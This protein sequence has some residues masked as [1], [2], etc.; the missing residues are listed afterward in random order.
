MTEEAQGK[1]GYYST[2][3]VDTESVLRDVSGRALPVAFATHRGSINIRPIKEVV[4]VEV[5][6]SYRGARDVHRVEAKSVPRP[7]RWE[8]LDMRWASGVWGATRTMSLRRRV[9]ITKVLYDKHFHGKNL[10]K[11]NNAEVDT[12]CKLCH[13]AR[14]GQQHILRECCEP[15]MVR[16]RRRQETSLH[17]NVCTAETKRDPMAR[18]YRGYNLAVDRRP[19]GHEFWTGVYSE[20]ALSDLEGI[21]LVIGDIPTDR[22]FNSLRRYC[23]HYAQAAKALFVERARRMGEIKAAEARTAMTKAAGARAKPEDPVSHDI[24]KYATWPQQDGQ[25][26][27]YRRRLL[28]SDDE[29]ELAL[30]PV[31]QR[32]VAR[33][34][35]VIRRYVPSAAP[36]RTAPPPEDPA[37]THASR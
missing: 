1:V 31:D 15:A 33:S 35:K 16:C 26:E 2:C 25:P 17:R 24:R 14:D 4:T 28:D 29:D 20:Q 19:D 37:R 27:G 13:S 3:Q 18:F 10:A 34:A 21:E 6:R 7:P 23:G 12:T 8:G 11:F 32:A 30:L 5:A 36:E 9:F 22:Q